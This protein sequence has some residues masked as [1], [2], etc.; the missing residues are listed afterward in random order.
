MTIFTTTLKRILVQP[1]N[2]VLIVIFPLIFTIIIQATVNADRLYDTDITS[3][4]RFGVVDNDNTVLSRTLI[5]RLNMRYNIVEIEQDDITSTLTDSLVPWV[6]LINNGYE[7]DIKNGIA[8][9]LEGYSLT[10][11]DASALG[12]VATANLTR[13]LLILG[14]DDEETLQTWIE[15]SHVDVTLTKGD[16]WESLVFW[17]GYYGY[18]SLFTS[19]FIVKTL[20]DDKKSGMPDR[21]GVLP[22]RTG[23]VLIQGTLAA[24]IL[25]EVTA[26]LLLLVLHLLVGAIPNVILLFAL[27]SLYNLFSVGFVLAIL[28]S[29]RSV[30]T[31]SVVM[32]VFATL[33]A[34]LGGLFWPIDLVPAFMQKLAWFSPGYWFASG[35]ENLREVTIEGYGL[36]V[37]FL[38]GFSVVVILFG[39]WGKI[40]RIEE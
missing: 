16:T 39:G 34:M 21:L 30:A 22:Q 17:L 8:L 31:S 7:R 20:V 33:S 2:L 10:I 35:I 15:D 18:I 1:I 4:M 3:T 26:I 5:S 12:S 36:S 14:T 6:L 24:L 19:Y 9:E 37:L 40:S 25:T 28:S 32:T 27:L 23:K 13:S 29:L 11:S 38:A